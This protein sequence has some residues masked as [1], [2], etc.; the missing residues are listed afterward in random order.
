VQTSPHSLG[1]GPRCGPLQRT[2]QCVGRGI[3][4]RGGHGEQPTTGERHPGPAE[5]SAASEYAEVLCGVPSV[6]TASSTGSRPG[7]RAAGPT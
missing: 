2:E 4:T 7:S 1:T 6:S 5:G 3:P